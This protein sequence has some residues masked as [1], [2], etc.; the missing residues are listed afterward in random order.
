MKD[1]ITLILEEIKKINNKLDNINNYIILNNKKKDIN[2]NLKL[3]DWNNVHN[4]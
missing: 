2:Y 3:V 4:F 1:N